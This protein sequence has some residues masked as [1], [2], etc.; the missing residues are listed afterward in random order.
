MHF[1]FLPYN[2]RK[3]LSTKC[4]TT[5]HQK[6]DVPAG[7]SYPLGATVYPN[8]VNFSIFSNHGVAVD[9]LLFDD[10]E[11]MKP[12]RSIR[13]DSVIN[14]TAHY[15]HIFL[16]GVTSGQLYAYR[17]HGPYY[18]KLGCRYDG[19]KV[20]LDPYTR[21]V[22][23]SKKYDRTAAIRPGDNCAC[24]LKSVVVDTSRYDWSGDMPL[25]KPYSQTIIYEMH[26]HGFTRHPNSGVAPEKRGTYA[27]LIEKIPYL[28]SLGITAVE[29]LP[30]QQFDDQD[31][32]RA[33]WSI[34]G[35]TV[36]SLFSRRTAPTVPAVI[37]SDLLRSFATWS[38]RSTRPTS[39]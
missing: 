6:Y 11:D 32:L 28:K 16:P 36:R 5:M 10:V 31:A 37:R 22:A 24:A 38:R 2:R 14:K 13:L 29:L 18:P 17:V 27:G 12:S 15:W 4:Q 19:E 35:V 39:K 25:H 34:T 30:V 20:L 9:L 26:V 3:L 7:H 33:V 23:V 21:A 8:G 1:N